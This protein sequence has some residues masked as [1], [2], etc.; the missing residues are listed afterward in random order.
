VKG[1]GKLYDLISWAIWQLI[2]AAFGFVFVTIPVLS[3]KTFN[4]FCRYVARRYPDTVLSRTGKPRLPSTDSVNL[5]GAGASEWMP[6]SKTWQS[7]YDEWPDDSEIKKMSSTEIKKKILVVKETMFFGYFGPLEAWL[8]SK[9]QGNFYLWH[10][11]DRIYLILTD[12]RDMLY[13]N[14]KWDNRLPTVKEI[15]KV[16]IWNRISQ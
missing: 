10:D 12:S 4:T 2:V 7:L 6:M 8:E 1:L 9:C 16:I 13:Y 3:I 14:L 11:A 15:E 5:C